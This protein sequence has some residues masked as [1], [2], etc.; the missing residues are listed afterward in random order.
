MKSY[1]AGEGPDVMPIGTGVVGVEI[2]D[3]TEVLA[4]TILEVAD[5]VLASPTRVG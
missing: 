3:D 1:L 2:S 5:D 4:T